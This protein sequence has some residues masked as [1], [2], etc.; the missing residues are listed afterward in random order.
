MDKKQQEVDRQVHLGHCNMGEYEDSCKYGERK[1]CPALKQMY[2]YEVLYEEL[3]AIHECDD[4]GAGCE[5]QEYWTDFKGLYA[6]K[7]RYYRCKIRR[8]AL[9]KVAYKIEEKLFAERLST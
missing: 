2:I 6:Q 7:S 4:Y 1:G 8:E 9:E 5:I 3:I